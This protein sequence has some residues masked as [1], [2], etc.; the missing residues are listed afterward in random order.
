MRSV[1]DV[2]DRLTARVV[3]SAA[4]AAVV[5][6]G[7]PAGARAQSA[8]IYGSLSN[9]DISNDTG[10]VCHGFEVQLD[11]V[12]VSDYGGSFTAN[13]YGTPTVTP[14][15]T[16]IAVTWRSPVSTSTQ[17]WATRTLPHTVPWFSGQCYQWVPATYENGGCEHFGTYTTANPT[18]VTSRWLCEGS[19]DPSSLVAVDPPTAVPYASYYVVPPAQPNNPPQLVAEVDAPEPAEVAGQFGDAQWTR[20]YKLELPRPLTL[21][22]LMADNPA[23]PADLSQLESDY[24]ILQDEP[25][26]GG[27]G[28]RKRHRTQGSID[29]TTRAVVRRIEVY[30]FTGP[31]DPV[32]HEALCADLLCN[33]PAADELGDL[34]DV[35]ITAA[36]V[37]PDA[38]LV[39]KVGNGNVESADRLVACGNKCTQP[40]EANALVTLSVKPGSDS[41]FGGWSGACAGTQSTCT[42]TINGQV[43]VGATFAL[44]P[45]SG[46]GGGSTG[47]G[48]GTSTQYS[49]QVGRS[50]PG[51]VTATPTGDKA[52]NCGKDCSA[53]YA[54]G[55][56]VTLTAVPPAGAAFVGWGG[57]CSGTDP[58]CV[59]T[60]NGAKSVQANFSK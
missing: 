41:T 3:R 44:V 18:K 11:G 55:T 51:T 14:T 57:A 2:R 48:G 20:V 53:K 26:A 16:G 36:N 17:G 40:Y 43:N 4:V 1:R 7:V 33:A 19:S 21:D 25:P 47:G 59:L 58:Q 30:A 49:L 24:Q 15:A 10:R 29:P 54:A 35:Q 34:L 6:L 56:S 9:F 12:Q 27:N 46:G 45:R 39:S 8:I 52:I 38:L 32:T 22:E 31:Y 60:M 50:N 28:R 42:V 13:R 23:M 37:Q 5:A